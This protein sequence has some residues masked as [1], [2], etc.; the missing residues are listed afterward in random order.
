MAD[1]KTSSEGK[2]EIQKFEY[3]ENENSF[4]DEKKTFFIII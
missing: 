1:R 4:L 3:F 2:L